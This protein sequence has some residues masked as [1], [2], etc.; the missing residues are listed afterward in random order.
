MGKPPDRTKSSKTADAVAESLLGEMRDIAAQLHETAVPS[1]IAA[2]LAAGAP[3][4]AIT[5]VEAVLDKLRS[6][7]MQSLFHDDDELRSLF[8]GMGERKLAKM[9]VLTE[10]TLDLTSEK[11]QRTPIAQQSLKNLSM[12]L[13]SLT[14]Q[15]QGMSDMMAKAAANSAERQRR[16]ATMSDDELRQQL[17]DRRREAED[18]DLNPAEP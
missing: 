9:M 16:R 17:E 10:R 2:A 8:G 15:A 5:D 18:L 7:G 14:R 6:S 1:E 3:E 4:L 11:L 12:I 13:D